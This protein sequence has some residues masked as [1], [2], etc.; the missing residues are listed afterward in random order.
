MRAVA[1]RFTADR[2]CVI[3]APKAV[4][5]EAVSQISSLR[6]AGI[7]LRVA[8]GMAARSPRV[9]AVMRAARATA[10]SVAH[11]LHLLW[12]EVTGTVFLAMAGV[13]G[14]A[15][16]REYAKYAAGRATAGRF[17]IAVYV[18][19]TLTFAWFGLSSFWRVHRKSQRP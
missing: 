11:I 19:F 15:L 14:I 12:L 10:R 6:K 4:K 3:V 18:C 16:A 8:R 2:V 7:A 13:G 5:I 17:A 1:E 9:N